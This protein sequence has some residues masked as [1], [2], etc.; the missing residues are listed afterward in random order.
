MEVINHTKNLKCEI[1]IERQ[2]WTTRITHKSNGTV[3]DSS[4]NVK[5]EITGRWSEYLSIKDKNSGVEEEIWR[6]EEK[7]P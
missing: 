6:A 7:H 2:G 3:T 4:G 1:N 5:F